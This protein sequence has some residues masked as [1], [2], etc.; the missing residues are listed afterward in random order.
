[1]M[2]NPTR[3]TKTF[4]CRTKAQR[5]ELTTTLR[6]IGCLPRTGS[7]TVNITG[8]HVVEVYAYAWKFL[9]KAEEGGNHE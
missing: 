9:T 5:K 4:L 7:L 6:E 3:V 8:G 2:E 1:M